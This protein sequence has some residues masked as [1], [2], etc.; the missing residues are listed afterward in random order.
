MEKGDVGIEIKRN[1]STFRLHCQC[2]VPIR[3]SLDLPSLPWQFSLGLNIFF[4]DVEKFEARYRPSLTPKISLK[5][6]KLQ[7][8]PNPLQLRLSHHE[9]RCELHC[10]HR[11]FGHCG[12]PC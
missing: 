12:H 7:R 1:L 5:T 6:F 8:W 4:G 11:Y 2:T 3:A 9:L 10:A